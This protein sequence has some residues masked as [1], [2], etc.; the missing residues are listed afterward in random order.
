MKTLHHLDSP[1]PT[2]TANGRKIVEDEVC[3]CGKLRSEHAD[4]VVGWG[5]GPCEETNCIRFTWRRAVYG[6]RVIFPGT[7]ERIVKAYQEG[8][9]PEELWGVI[10]AGVRRIKMAPAPRAAML[11]TYFGYVKLVYK[12][13]AAEMEVTDARVAS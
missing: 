8:I 4:L 12:K 10:T 5:H 2:P 1:F 11:A 3:L 13:R 9:A 7:M 6:E